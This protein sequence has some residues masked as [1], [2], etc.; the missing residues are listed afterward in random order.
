MNDLKIEKTKDKLK[1]TRIETESESEGS[2]DM[3]VTRRGKNNNGFTKDVKNKKFK[4]NFRK[5]KKPGLSAKF[6]FE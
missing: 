2:E 5:R 4:K 3:I 6:L 1:I